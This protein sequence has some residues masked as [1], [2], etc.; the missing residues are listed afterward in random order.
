LGLNK[1]KIMIKKELDNGIKLYIIR[2]NEKNIRLVVGVKM[3]SIYEDIPGIS[4]FLEHMMFKSNKKYSAKQIDEGLELCG[5][6]SNAFTSTFLTCYVSE[7]IPKGFKKVADIFSSMFEN[8]KFKEE[9]FEKEKK[10]ILSEIERIENNPEDRLDALIPYS[11][12]GD[13][14]YGRFIAGNRESVESIEK[15]DLEEFKSK[16]YVSKNMFIVL[17]GNVKRDQIKFLENKFSKI[18]DGKVKIKRASKKNG[19][20]VEEKLKTKNQIYFSLS[21]RFKVKKFFDLEALSYMLSGGISSKT[22]QIFRNKYGIGYHIDLEISYIYPDEIILSLLIPG[23]EKE[24]EK[25]LEN[26]IEDF[27]NVEIDEKY[28]NGRKMRT[29]IALEKERED[30]KS[31][32]ILANLIAIFEKDYDYYVSQVIK[33]MNL[34]ITKYL[35]KLKRG[36]RVYIFPK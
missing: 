22:F 30:I 27:V 8:D 25:F 33:R 9:E 36:K 2:K 16:Y 32:L 29:K 21:Q 15:E 3:G 1:L 31:L 12:Y 4:H 35:N 26:A 10:V 23:F 6:I 20:N 24:R 18:V 14:D 7:V 34:G 17:E 5:S 28:V 19:K 13:S 11:V